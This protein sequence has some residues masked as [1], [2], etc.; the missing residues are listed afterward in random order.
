M[1]FEQFVKDSISVWCDNQSAIE[2]SKNAVFHKR[3]KHIDISF[4]FTTELVEKK[5]ITIQYLRT[6][7]MIADILT[8]SLSKDKHFKYISMLQ[9]E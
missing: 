9:L 1:G 7:L 4:H 3:S 5:V 6:E 8:K 2:L